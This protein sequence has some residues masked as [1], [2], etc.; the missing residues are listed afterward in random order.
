MANTADRIGLLPGFDLLAGHGFWL[1]VT[2]CWLL[3]PVGNLLIG[4]IGESRLVPVDSWNGRQ[5]WSFF[6]GDLV[7]GVAAAVLL[8][9][10]QNLPDEQRWYNHTVWHFVVLV[11]CAAVAVTLTVV[12]WRSGAYPPAAILSPTK[13]YHNG[14]LYIGYG[15]VIVATLTACLFGGVLRGGAIAVVIGLIWM[16]LLVCDNMVSEPEATRRASIAHV[17]DWK[18]LWR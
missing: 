9:S 11:A 10:S 2:F 14:V 1:T 5:F 16:A 12:E 15:Y 7:L 4:A 3:T 8:V 17:P 18:P 6:P 13:L